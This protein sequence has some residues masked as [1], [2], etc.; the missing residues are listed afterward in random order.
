MS[1]YN[2]NGM[3]ENEFEKQLKDLMDEFKLAPSTSV[4]EKVSRRLNE[5]RRK[6][7]PF[8]FLLFLGLL[9]AGYFMYQYG[10]QQPQSIHYA[11]SKTNKGPERDSLSLK[12]PGQIS[13]EK[14][15]GQ[16]SSIVSANKNDHTVS[17]ASSPKTNRPAVFV[18][19]ES[20]Y[21]NSSLSINVVS[22]NNNNSS[23]QL[24]IN[25]EITTNDVSAVMEKQLQNNAPV[26]E[27][28]VANDSTK[29]I[30]NAARN[31]SLNKN[32]AQTD[33][34]QI[35]Q[36]KKES[37]VKRIA[38]NPSNKNYT[39]PKWQWGIN[40]FYGRSNA[41]KNLV[42]F[43]KAA[44]ANL[45]YS[46]RPVT[47]NI[48]TAHYNSNPYTAS[49]AYRFGFVVQKKIIK[50]GFISS[51]LNFI[52]LSTKSDVTGKKDSA[53]TVQNGNI[54]TNS[55]YVSSFYQP[56]PSKTYT[57]TYNFIE[58]PVYFQQ[59]VF[60]RHKLSLSY[61][62]GFSM[63]QLLSSNALIYNRY[64]DI[65]YS[66]D[67]LLRKTQWQFLAG[68][69]LKINTGKKVAVY[70]GPEFS[71]SLSNLLKDNDAGNFHLINYGVQAGLMFHKK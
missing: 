22:S 53:Y 32:I 13:T 69:N 21:K 61:N 40:A 1:T 42:D 28:I 2:N 46:P 14:T 39:I 18:K 43:N 4:W 3:Q 58:I 37:A 23:G 57:N 63:R 19:K 47:G 71:Y 30:D 15:T 31:D 17:K 70:I 36:D 62:A 5:G 11:N 8:I 54:I 49:N 33:S 41:I 20:K 44:P 25:P 67:E 27:P 52:H 48:D 7:R 45:D 9:V 34:M 10:R 64:N 68:V 29:L 50:N 59:D 38:K 26:N 6:K 66:K 24:K 16:N 55:F 56:G 51:G 60:Y 12:N 35:N 65:Y